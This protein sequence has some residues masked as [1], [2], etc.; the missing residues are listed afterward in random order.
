MIFLRIQEMAAKYGLTTYTL[1]FYERKGLLTPSRD[2]RGDRDYTPT[3]QAAVH[4][5]TQYRR[6]G[7]SVDEIKQ[8]FTGMKTTDMLTL[9][10]K[11]QL[12]VQEEQRQLQETAQFL[13]EKIA[14]E[15]ARLAQG[16]QTIP[17][18]ADDAAA[19]LAIEENTNV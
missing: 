7:L 6:A 10:A 18:P 3:E 17:T 14:H 12:H 1:R 5:I 19:N 4:R 2:S 9:L 8:I 11:T 13:T 15:Q 16:G